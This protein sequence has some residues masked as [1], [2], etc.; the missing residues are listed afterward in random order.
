MTVS[1]SMQ[2]YRLKTMMRKLARI[3]RRRVVLSEPLPEVR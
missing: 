3:S 1:T 2:W